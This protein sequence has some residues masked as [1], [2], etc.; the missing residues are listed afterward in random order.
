MVN[1]VTISTEEYDELRRIKNEIYKDNVFE[2]KAKGYKWELSKDR[3][4][5]DRFYNFEIAPKDKV[6]EFLSKTIQ[7]LTIALAES[8]EEA[9]AYSKKIQTIKCHLKDIN[10]FNYKSKIKIIKEFKK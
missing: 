7:D 3:W 10:I 6:D 1:T 4:I 9:I 5:P 8:E 2:L